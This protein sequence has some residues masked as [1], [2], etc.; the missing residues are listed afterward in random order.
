[1]LVRD[2]EC[3]PKLAT[4]LTDLSEISPKRLRVTWP[5]PIIVQTG[6]TK[7]C[8]LEWLSRPTNLPKRL[9]VIPM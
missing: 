9:N 2:Q 7:L 6:A 8:R 5:K 3:L 4:H 1:M